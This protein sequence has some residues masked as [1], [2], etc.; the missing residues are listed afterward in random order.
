MSM[1][2]IV[3]R[4]VPTYMRSPYSAGDDTTGP[5]TFT[6]ARMPP[7]SMLSA[8]IRPNHPARLQ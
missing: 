6:C 7:P 2:Y 5:S 8:I 3:P 4:S 1:Q